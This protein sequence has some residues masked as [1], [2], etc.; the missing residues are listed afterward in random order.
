MMSNETGHENIAVKLC[1]LFVLILFTIIL[2]FRF[3]EI[4]GIIVIIF[5]LLSV[6]AITILMAITE[7]LLDAINP[8]KVIRIMF[9][10]GKSYLLLYLFLMLMMGSSELIE[11][12]AHS[13]VNE[14]VLG[15]LIFFINAYFTVAMFS[16]MGYAIYQYHEEFGFDGVAEVNL[17]EEGINL[18]ASGISQDSF[19]NEIHILVSEGM[20]EKAINRLKKQI[21]TTQAS[22]AYHDKYH[23]LLKLANNP[24]EMATHTTEYIDLLLT[25]AKVN[26]GAL[27]NIYT[28][29]LKMNPD[30]FYPNPKITVNLA[31]TAQELF[32]NQDALSLLTN[33][34]Q[35]Y[36]N[37]EQIPYAYFMVAQILIDYKQQD[38]QAKRILFSLLAKYPDHDLTAQIKDYLSTIEKF[39]K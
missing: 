19:L 33:F 34:S 9:G 37:S 39:T 10:M 26:Q 36:P 6:P 4:I 13:V 8:V 24:Q 25:Q 1:V 12:W 11:Y 38:E 7:S 35:H 21:K 23:A 29:C 27:I 2:A 18:R 5:S 16:M 15:P 3:N 30:Y 31:K 17:A 32:R 22:L 14:F 28:D 20:L